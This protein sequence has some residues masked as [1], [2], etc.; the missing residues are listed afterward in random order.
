MFRRQAS[1]INQIQL[2]RQLSIN[3]SK[4]ISKCSEACH[5]WPSKNSNPKHKCICKPRSWRAS[6]YTVRFISLSVKLEC[7]SKLAF[8][9]NLLTTGISKGL[10]VKISQIVAVFQSV[11]MNTLLQL[12]KRN[13]CFTFT[14]CLQGWQESFQR[15][16]YSSNF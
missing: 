13:I 14:Y 8:L 4:G 7:F 6:E 12:S 1:W 3:T 16:W 10:T 15:N 2:G 5:Q 11:Q 9:A